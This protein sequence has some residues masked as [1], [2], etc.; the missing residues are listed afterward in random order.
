VADVRDPLVVHH[1]DEFV[2]VDEEVH[3]FDS[4]R[5]NR[6]RSFSIEDLAISQLL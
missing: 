5:V 1:A 6:V 2:V 3:H 4:E